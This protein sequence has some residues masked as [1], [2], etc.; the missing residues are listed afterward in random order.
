M[1]K[2]ILFTLLLFAQWSMFNVQCSMANAQNLYIGSFYVTTTDEEALYGDGGDKWATRRTPICDMFNFEQP[3]VLG[4]QSA[5]ETQISYIA[6]R[7]T[8]HNVAGNI[9]YN[10]TTLELLENG[11]VEDMPEGSTCSWAKLKKGEKAFYVF[12]ICFS[13]VQSTATSSTTRLR[14]A[15]TEIKNENVPVFIVGFLGVNE[16]KTPYSRMTQSLYNDCFKQAPVVSAEYG[17]VNNFDLAANHGTERY[18]FI[19]AS[20]TVS[21]KAYGQLQSGYF[22]KESDGSYKRRLLSTHFPVMAKVTLP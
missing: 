21:V 18:D 9:L 17:T 19:F 16:T 22:T 11:D 8:N 3:D 6:T 4:L 1:K 5:T 14:S 13:T 15:I 10:K 7:L 2:T 20:R 12:N